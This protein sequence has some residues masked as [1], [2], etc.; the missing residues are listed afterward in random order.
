MGSLLR[1][2][3]RIRTTRHA[4]EYP[5]RETWIDA[6]AVS[7]DLP[8]TTPTCAGKILIR[9]QMVLGCGAQPGRKRLMSEVGTAANGL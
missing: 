2:V 3:D 5:D 6:D 4:A 9:R 8:A 1:P 7:A